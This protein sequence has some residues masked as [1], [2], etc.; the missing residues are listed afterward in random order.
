MTGEE[1]LQTVHGHAKLARLRY[2]Y[3]TDPGFHRQLCKK[4]T[5]TP[6]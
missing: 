5:S 3:D 6:N 4:A 1:K 2:V